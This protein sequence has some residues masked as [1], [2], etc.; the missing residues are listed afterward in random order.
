[1]QGYL[2]R[3]HGVREA[4]CF[5]D[6]PKLIRKLRPVRRR[7]LGDVNHSHLT[8][9]DQLVWTGQDIKSRTFEFISDTTHRTEILVLRIK[10]EI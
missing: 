10:S 9:A 7:R 5:N 2:I 3:D 4:T 1:M 8:K 6:P